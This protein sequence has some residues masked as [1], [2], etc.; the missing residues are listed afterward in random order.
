MLFNA[1][2]I[3]WLCTICKTTLF[4]VRYV[5]SQF[6]GATTLEQKELLVFLWYRES[7]E[8]HYDARKK[9]TEGTVE[10]PIRISLSHDSA[11]ISPEL[12]ANNIQ[13]TS[14]R[15]PQP[16]TT[17]NRKQRT[18]QHQP[19][20]SSIT[21]TDKVRLK[22]GRLFCVCGFLFKPTI[23]LTIYWIYFKARRRFHNCLKHNIRYYSSHKFTF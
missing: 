22:E 6:N 19:R 4:N 15:K 18:K 9:T 3:I 21:D 16:M 7:Q 8:D 11:L 12:V 1:R 10:D 23:Q 20:H 2:K 13:W 5:S 17:K 14:R